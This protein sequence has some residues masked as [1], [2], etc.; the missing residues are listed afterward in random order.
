LDSAFF[1]EEG[2][3]TGKGV[4]EKKNEGGAIGGESAAS[5]FLAEQEVIGDLLLG[6]LFEG[7]LDVPEEGADVSDVDALTGF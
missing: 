2:P 4:S 7:R 5:G 1:L 6:N 3:R